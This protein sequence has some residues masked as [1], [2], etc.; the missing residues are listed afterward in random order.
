MKDLGISDEN[1]RR[2][3]GN[4]PWVGFLPLKFAEKLGSFWV[5]TQLQP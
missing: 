1:I 4:R 3:A 5:E 2:I